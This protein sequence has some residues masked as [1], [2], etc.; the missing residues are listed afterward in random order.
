[1]ANN[2]LIDGLES[3]I[4]RYNP[5]IIYE[6]KRC[7][8][9]DSNEFIVYDGIYVCCK[10]CGLIAA[11]LSFQ[12]CDMNKANPMGFNIIH[13]KKHNAK[14]KKIRKKKLMKHAKRKIKEKNKR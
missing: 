9:C 1:M 14:N 6:H 12:T 4:P 2:H 8:F 11:C 3:H 13:K 7:K 5:T 10:R